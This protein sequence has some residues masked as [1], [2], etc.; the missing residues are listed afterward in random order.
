[1]SS[2]KRLVFHLLPNAHLDP[3]WLWDWREGLNE[4]LITVRTI[5]DLMDEY[6][7]LTFMR[8]ESSIYEHI[9]KTDRGVF[10]RILARIEDG[11]WDVVG[12]TVV[13]P[14][15]NLASTEILCR[16]YER[17][18][19]YFEKNLGVRPTVAW[20]ADSFGHTPGLPNILSSFGMKGFSFTRPQQN[21]FP[22]D[23]P[24]FWWEG[25]SKNRILCYRQHWMWYCSDRS[26]LVETLDHTLAEANKT[27][28][29]HVGVLF[30]LGNHGGGP[31]RRHLQE[32]ELWKQQ[33]PEVEVVYDTLH[34]FFGKLE[35]EISTKEEEALPTLKG[36]LGYCLRGCYSS[37][38]K[39]KSAYRKSEA[40]L[41]DAEITRSVIGTAIP[42]PKVDLTEAWDSL[43]FNSFHDILPGTSIERA[44]EEQTAWVGLATHRSLQARFQAL[45]QLVAQI[46]TSVPPPAHADLPRDVP[47]LIWNPLPRP[48]QGIVEAEVPLDYRPISF[49]RDRA[50]ELPVIV[51]DQAGEAVPF[52]VVQ[53][54][55]TSMPE[56]PWRRR[57]AV[58]VE[59]PAWG[60][61]V[62]Q[63]GWRKTPE[64]YSFPAIC[65]S[66]QAPY[67]QITNGDWQVS[68][69]EGQV[70][71]SR[72]GANFFSGDRNFELMVVEDPWGS[73]GGLHEE[74]E[75]YLLGNLKEKW[76]LAASEV[77]ESGPLRA[78]LW[79]RW[80]GE[81]SW[82]DL[83][84]STT[85]NSPALTVEGRML[86][87][88]RCAR[89]KLAFPCSGPLKYDMPGGRVLREA[90]G[91][92]P[93]GRWV[94]RGNG[95]GTLGFASDVLSDFDA[96]S[97]ELRVTL[98]RSTRYACDPTYAPTE[99]M[100]EP[101]VDCGE[102]KFQFSLFGADA[103]PDHVTDALRSAPTAV[104]APA[105]K[106]PWLREGS[107]GSITPESISLLS[108]EELDSEHV[109]VRLQNRD[110][111]SSEVTLRLG[112]SALDLGAIDP[113]EIK[114]ILLE[115]DGIGGWRKPFEASIDLIDTSVRNLDLYQ[116][117]G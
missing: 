42:G 32:V 109:R 102:L 110:E 2:S 52:Q 89:L 61:T 92:V 7:T 51:Y 33:H 96:T 74:K 104:I 90:D 28:L 108:F 95:T 43:L 77:L 14:D 37:V 59:L 18:L 86:W 26:N 111:Q 91:Q 20:Q 16:Q 103:N 72:G 64:P 3:V 98:A 70:R 117:V 101:V 39:F 27:D 76:S 82:I 11:R 46:D 63:V 40:Q 34:G 48:F 83:T 60:W 58:P 85:A 55:H 75:S 6:P 114:T 41:A 68:A 66:L 13:Q 50:H 47:V 9:Q 79:T 22:L 1:M 56:V 87:N 113:L 67:P 88:E 84:F 10:D 15:T 97:D 71:I 94:V 65:S 12:G 99:K 62:L 8:G 106:G 23:T 21:E 53:T 36:D 29:T 115:K 31:T 81:N 44:M 25:D 69:Q 45:N 112:T 17:G 19:S 105:Q 93:G 30:G 100:W 107:L 73:W 80:K 78:K 54:E 57:V 5:L 116:S 49:F 38:Q 24:A 4:G 35:E